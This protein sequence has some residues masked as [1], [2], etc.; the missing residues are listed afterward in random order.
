MRAS[1]WLVRFTAA[2]RLGIAVGFIPSGLRKVMGERF[3]SLGLDDPVGFFF[4]A[5]YR[6]QL[7]YRTVGWAQVIAAV[8]LIFPRT[9]HLGAFIFFPVIFNIWLVTVGIH[10]QGTWVITSLMLLANLWLLAWEYDRLVPLLTVRARGTTWRESTLT[11]VSAFAASG[12]VAY[13]GLY[14]FN[15]ARVQSTIGLTG[16]V[17]AAVAGGVYGAVAAWHARGIA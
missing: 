17:V 12:T 4:E 16:F 6:N 9:A 10:F 7:W 5:F 8:L 15:I 11:W 2:T 1:P 13:S 14:A 3:T